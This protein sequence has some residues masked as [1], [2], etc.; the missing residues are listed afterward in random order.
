MARRTINPQWRHTFVFDSV[1]GEELRER[2]LELC[3][4]DHDRFSSN[5]FLGGVRI[6]SGTGK[7]SNFLSLESK[8]SSFLHGCIV[9]FQDRATERRLHGTTLVTTNDRCGDRCSN[10]PT[11]GSTQHFN[12]D[13]TWILAKNSRALA[14][15][16][17]CSN[18]TSFIPSSPNEQS[19][20][21]PRS[22]NIV[23]FLSLEVS[24]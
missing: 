5:S 6:G 13:P 7:T 1:N 3:V 9:W 12:S 23:F 21:L 4:W 17:T 14:A 20:F 24:L 16:D 10:N 15:E 11:L 2:A 22:N 18:M 19:H 8:L